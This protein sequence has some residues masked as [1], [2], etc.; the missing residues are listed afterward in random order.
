M[1]IIA[2]FTIIASA[3]VTP[4]AWAAVTVSDAWVRNTGTTTAAVY[5]RI[6]SDQPA[7]L[8]GLYSPAAKMAGFHEMK[9]Q[10]GMMQMRPIQSLDLPAGQTIEFKPGGYHGMLSEITTPLKDGSAVPLRFTVEGADHHA[11]SVDVN[12]VVK[13]PME[14]DHG[15]AN[16]MKGMDGMKG[17]PGM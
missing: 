6:K 12:A 1:K 7:K 11:Q 8:T 16:G 17:M 5:F 3:M 14:K 9:M 15:E 10:G 13:G 4:S 2:V